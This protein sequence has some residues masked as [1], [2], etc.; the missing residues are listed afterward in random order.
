[1]I[2]WGNKDKTLRLRIVAA[3]KLGAADFGIGSLGKYYSCDP[4]TRRNA[5]AGVR[6]A[7]KELLRHCALL[8][9]RNPN[10]KSRLF[11]RLLPGRPTL[12]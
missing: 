11:V 8:C 6:N 12:G 5:C 3:S 4:P 9:R 10:E 7:R 1:M 2:F